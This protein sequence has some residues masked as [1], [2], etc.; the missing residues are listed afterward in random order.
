MKK[1]RCI[2]LFL[3]VMLSSCEDQQL[4]DEKAR[5]TITIDLTLDKSEKIGDVLEYERFI[6]LET[7]DS[8]IINEINKIAFTD[9]FIFILDKRQATI[10]IFDKEGKFQYPIKRL[11]QGPEE[12]LETSDI[13]VDAQRKEIYVLDGLAGHLLKYSIKGEYLDKVIVPQAYQMSKTKDGEWIFYLANGTGNYSKNDKLNNILI[14]D[15]DFNLI[16]EALPF[17]ETLCGHVYSYGDIKYHLSEYQNRIYINPQLDNNIYIYNP[18]DK[19]VEMEYKIDFKEYSNLAINKN[20]TS[21]EIKQIV[22]R[23]N[24]KEIPSTV[25]NF[26]KLENMLFFN[27]RYKDSKGNLLCVFDEERKVY[28]VYDYLFEDNGLFFNPVVYDS[29]EDKRDVILSIINGGEY[30]ICKSLE[31]ESELFKE[32]RTT[33]GDIND[34]NPILVFY[35]LRPFHGVR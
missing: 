34:P 24:T 15:D 19:Q 7:T 4:D 14:Y 13:Y 30:E 6:V 23:I 2:I 10:W 29:S 33:V 9:E 22:S 18:K 20:N 21:D 28:Q 25:N 11:G 17:P 16:Y 1:T 35:N 12:Y 27:F 31:K 32:I 3:A 8:C 26:Y 5:T